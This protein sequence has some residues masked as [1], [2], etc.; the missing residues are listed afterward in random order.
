MGRS[1]ETRSDALLEAYEE[2]G[3]FEDYF[4]NILGFEPDADEDI[5]YENWCY[6]DAGEEWTWYRDD[7]K[8]RMMELFPSFWETERW[9]SGYYAYYL[10]ETNVYLENNLLEVSVSE[11]CGLTYIAVAAKEGVNLGLAKAVANKMRAKFEENFGQYKKV[12][13]FSNG[14]SVYVK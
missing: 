4:E 10:R 7:F 2:W 6:N 11:Y 3:N 12:G 5:A 1:V 13:T 9:P 14:E 8:S